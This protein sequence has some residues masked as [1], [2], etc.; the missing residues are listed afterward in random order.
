MRRDVSDVPATVSKVHNSRCH[1]FLHASLQLAALCE[2]TSIHEVRET[3]ASFPTDIEDLY[4]KTWQRILALKGRKAMSARNALTWVVFGTRSLTIQELREA[5]AFHPDTHK[6]E[7]DRL[8]PETTLIGL[9]HGLVTVEKGT[10]LV[11]LVR[12]L[13]MCFLHASLLTSAFRLY[14]KGHLSGTNHPNPSTTSRAPSCSLFGPIYRHCAWLA[15]SRRG[16]NGGGF[17][18]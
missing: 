1:R 11:R 8:V 18:P 17:L 2:C 13:I 10:S 4:R 3:L 12:K 9:C 6:F 15:R 16:Q 5:V 7:R 14:R